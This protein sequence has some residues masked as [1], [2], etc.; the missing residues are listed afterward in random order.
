MDIAVVATTTMPDEHIQ[1]TAIQVEE[2]EKHTK[3][4]IR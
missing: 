1:A 4:T 2:E 3:K